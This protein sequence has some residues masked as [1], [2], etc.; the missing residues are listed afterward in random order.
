MLRRTDFLGG[1]VER[2]TTVLLRHGETTLAACT[3][4]AHPASQFAEL[5]LLAT[6]VSRGKIDR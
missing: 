4:V 5:L 2:G 6:S 3:F 1:M